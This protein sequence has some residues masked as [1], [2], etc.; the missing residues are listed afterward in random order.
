M[1]SYATLRDNTSS[2]EDGLTPTSASLSGQNLELASS[3]NDF[4]NNGCVKKMDTPTT[5]CYDP[6]SFSESER[7]K[8]DSTPENIK[9]IDDVIDEGGG[10]GHV[11]RDHKKLKAVQQ[12]Q[13]HFNNNY[14]L[15]TSLSPLSEQAAAGFG[16]SATLDDSNTKYCLAKQLCNIPKGKTEKK[17]YNLLYAKLL[18][19]IYAFIFWHK[20]K[21]TTKRFH[22]ANL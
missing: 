12:Q 21:N 15:P 1:T 22:I 2:I 11:R 3:V 20:Q 10:G 9:K 14:T 16:L 8:M 6:D 4:D 17:S 5:P 7:E 19:F 18:F 13:H